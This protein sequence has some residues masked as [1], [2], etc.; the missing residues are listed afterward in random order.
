MMSTT[1]YV[2]N[3]IKYISQFPVEWAKT[4]EPETGPEEC[5]NCAY[6]GSYRGIFIGYCANC[7]D[8]IYYGERGNG[9]I[10]KKQEK[11]KNYNQGNS[12]METYLKNV[13]IEEI[14]LSSS[15]DENQEL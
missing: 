15:E 2:L 7:A 3:G 12:A 11:N 6:F 10:T 8:Y 5:E 14:G 4:H 13:N 9:F 1:I